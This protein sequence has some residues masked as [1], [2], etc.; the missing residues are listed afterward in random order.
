MNHVPEAIETNRIWLRKYS[1]GDGIKF[2]CLMQHNYDRF[3]DNFPISVAAADNVENAEFWI[4]N[5]INGWLEQSMFSFAIFD[6]DSGALIGDSIIK[7]IDWM[8]PKAEIGYCISG[9]FEGKGLMQEVIWALNQLSFI[10]LGMERL[11]LKIAT[12]NDRSIKLAERCGYLKEGVLKHDYKKTDGDLVDIC[13]YGLIKKHYFNLI[14]KD[15][16]S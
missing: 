13:Y 6:K 9:E 10:K 5:K 1:K 3:K 4:Q 2:F 16:G 12:T 7:N 11:Y 8:V 14:E 15:S